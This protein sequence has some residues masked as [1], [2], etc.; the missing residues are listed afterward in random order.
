[1]KVKYKFKSS[2]YY[3][4][5]S[6]LKMLIKVIVCLIVISNSLCMVCNYYP[7]DPV[8]CIDKTEGIM[9]NFAIK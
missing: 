4:M 3:T 7:M 9:C 6:I 1:M 8:A 5:I 2:K